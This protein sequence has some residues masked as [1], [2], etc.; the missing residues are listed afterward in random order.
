VV[1]RLLQNRYGEVSRRRYREP[2]RSVRKYV[3]TGSGENRAEWPP[4]RVLLGAAGGGLEDGYDMIR[5][6]ER[7]PRG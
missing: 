1:A 7:T 3:S 2:E 6:T 5:S 4:E